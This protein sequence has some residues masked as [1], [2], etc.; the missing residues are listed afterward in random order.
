MNF[1]TSRRQLST[2]GWSAPTWLTPRVARCQRS[3][4]SHSAME[5]LNLSRTRALMARRTLRLPFKEWFSGSSTSRRST[6]TTIAWSV[7]TD[8][9]RRPSGRSLCRLD[10][11]AGRRQ[12]PRDLLHLVRL[13]HGPGLH[14]LIAFERH[15]ALVAGHDLARVVLEAFV[16]TDAA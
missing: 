8:R 5:T 4:S 15:A 6:P 11:L 9:S 16:S 3:W 1:T 2:C 13:E 7:P 14:V 12:P 10:A